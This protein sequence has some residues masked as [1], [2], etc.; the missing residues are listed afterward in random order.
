MWWKFNTDNAT[1]Q[2]T[3]IFC[4][5][6][7]TGGSVV[8][9][10]KPIEDQT[11]ARVPQ[12]QWFILKPFNRATPPHSNT[13]WQ[14]M[15]ATSNLP[16]YEET[17]A[18]TLSFCGTPTDSIFWSDSHFQT[19]ESAD[20]RQVLLVT[21]FLIEPS[22]R[23]SMISFKPEVNNKASET[24]RLNLPQA[25]CELKSAKLPRILSKQACS[26]DLTRSF[27]AKNELRSSSSVA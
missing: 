11:P 1:M 22:I 18:T 7:S 16:I 27:L 21:G 20:K 17:S 25:W 13:H 5:A 6:S 10:K 24:V 3:R 15:K 23:S 14:Y 8:I 4:A 26:K 9:L 2:E 19:I 12:E